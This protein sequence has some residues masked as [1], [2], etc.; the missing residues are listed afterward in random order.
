MSTVSFTF[1]FVFVILEN[2]RID[3]QKMMGLL[4]SALGIENT[5]A[6]L[7]TC[8]E[9][10]LS[11]LFVCEIIILKLNEPTNDPN[12]LT[13]CAYLE[14]RDLPYLNR[15]RSRLF[16]KKLL[17][18]ARVRMCATRA[19]GSL[20]FMPVITCIPVCSRYLYLLGIFVYK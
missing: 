8:K 12:F 18:G 6:P 5:I 1:S 10:A 17:I 9:H 13:F 15:V 20:A 19:R 16:V 3:P 2:T 7:F 14:E 4:A 11:L